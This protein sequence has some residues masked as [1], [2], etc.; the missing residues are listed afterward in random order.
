MAQASIRDF[1]KLHSFP[2]CPQFFCVCETAFPDG[3]SV[4]H[5]LNNQ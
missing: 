2:Y 3:S 1:L 5:E 4:G